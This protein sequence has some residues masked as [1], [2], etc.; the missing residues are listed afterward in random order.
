[1]IELKNVSK[2]FKR[3]NKF[4]YKKFNVLDDINIEIETGKITAILG[5]NGAGKTSI[6][7]TM[8]GLLK[9]DMGIVLVDGKK[10]SKDTY[11]I[12]SFIPDID[13]YFSGM[14]I[15]ETFEFM[16]FFYKN[17]DMKRAYEMIDIFGLDKN[18]IMNNLSKGNMA[19]IKLIIGFSQGA[20]YLLLDEPFSGI[21]FLK[22]E[23]FVGMIP[24]YMDEN[25]AI[26]I[27]TH[28]ISEIENIVDDVFFVDDGKVVLKI[29]AEE[30]RELENISILDKMREVYSNE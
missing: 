19:R 12:L 7:K 25:Q 23:E 29:N 18:Y 15:K 9:P 3:I 22:R 4:G 30:L 8:A 5:I 21:D 10:I 24:K 28:E 17:W 14:S 11:N 13:S 20:K 26:V 16:D 1:M 6:L 27:T 2:S